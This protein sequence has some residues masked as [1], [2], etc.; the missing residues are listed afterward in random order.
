MVV[1]CAYAQPGKPRRAG[2]GITVVGTSPAGVTFQGHGHVFQARSHIAVLEVHR[3]VTGAG[4]GVALL[5][6]TGDFIL[7][8]HDR[9]LSRISLVFTSSTLPQWSRVRWV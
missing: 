4:L 9:H 1:V 5:I 3:F 8:D 7:F 2:S 6:R